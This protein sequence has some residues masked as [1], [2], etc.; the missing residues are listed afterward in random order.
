MLERLYDQ[1]IAVKSII[2]RLPLGSN[3][4][5]IR[6]L[7]GSFNQIL[8]EMS[9]C[10]SHSS[11]KD[12]MRDAIAK[13]RR[14]IS[15]IRTR[16]D[17]LQSTIAVQYRNQI[18]PGKEDFEALS[19]EVQLK[20]NP[21]AYVSKSVFHALVS[22]SDLLSLIGSYLLNK[23]AELEQAKRR[24]LQAKAPTES[25]PTANYENDPAPPTWSP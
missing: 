7:E 21:E 4:E 15:Q 24:E 16:L 2:N 19:E 25:T 17:E 22:M 11:T 6:Q 20:T 3:T 23:S 1:L 10:N 12:E 5:E 8:V 18:G 14:G 13:M 9:V